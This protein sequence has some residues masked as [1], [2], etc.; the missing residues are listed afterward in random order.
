MGQGIILAHAATPASRKT[1]KTKNK[2]QKKTLMSSVH[3]EDLK[4][5]CLIF[6]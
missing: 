6:I 5:I 2:K 1:Q 4:L 3:S